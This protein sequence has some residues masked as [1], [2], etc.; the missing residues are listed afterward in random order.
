MSS[1]IKAVEVWEPDREKTV[2]T[3]GSGIY[4]KFKEFEAAS[5]GMTFAYDEG[6]PGKAWAAK[7]PIILT[8]LAG[9]YF[10]RVE[11]AAAIG[12]TAAIAMPVFAGEY[13]Q[14]VVLF[15]CGEKEEQSGAIE[16]WSAVPERLYEMGLVDGYYGKMDDFAWISRNLKIMK[17]RG[18]PGSTW[19]T[20]M[21]VIMKDLG[22]SPVFLRAKKAAQAGITTALAIPAWMH[23]EEGFVMTFLSSKG[24]P[25]ARRFEV[26]VPD[27]SE[28]VLRFSD[29]H[30]D[31]GTDLTS[32]YESVTLDR[33]SS[34]SGRVW[35]TGMPIVTQTYDSEE[36]DVIFDALLAVPILQNG[37]FKAV[38]KFYF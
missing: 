29:G 8:E 33:S 34:L 17:G 18:L 2:L 6:L 5:K 31:M 10:K 23:E 22:S 12:L 37:F 15:M 3:L 28:T 36:G 4:G 20:H 14:A 13:L 9:S 27:E 1:F 21:P 35:R 16:L 30:C 11:M 24:T 26:W 38:V 19:K 25:I 32:R 7:H